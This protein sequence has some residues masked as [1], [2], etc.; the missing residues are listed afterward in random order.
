MSIDVGK[1]IRELLYEHP[2]VIVPGLGG[3][4]ST[5]APASVDYVQGVVSPPSK[6]IEFNP[7]FV[8]NDGILV[9]HIQKSNTVTFQEAKESVDR[10]VED[11]K[12][13][14]ERR[15]IVEVTE[16][17]RLYKDY[18][19]KIRFMPEGTNFN[20]EAYGLPAVQFSP[21]VRERPA[22]AGSAKSSYQPAT[23][24]AVVAP[25]LPTNAAASP[26][27]ATPPP[28]APKTG[29]Q[30][31]LPWIVLLTAIILALSIYLLFNGNK[32]QAAENLESI[33]KERL[34]VKPKPDETPVEEEAPTENANAGTIAPPANST[35]EPAA[36]A[37]EEKSVP[38]T[39]DTEED[40]F[41]PGKKKCFIVVHS[42]GQKENAG[43]FARQLSEAG[44]AYDT[45]KVGDLY[46]VG[47]V[48][49]YDSPAQID[50]TVEEL[51]SKFKSTPKV[52]DEN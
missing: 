6:N 48:L 22:S 40:T 19:H 34:N 1:S 29:L 5:P 17:G 30:A 13:A 41:E 27:A 36:K 2:A 44:Y 32:K 42:F 24:T 25:V 15:E 23:E 31:L 14:L 12:E 8:V 21:V 20:A 9:N 46:R 52:F 51:S 49:A 7:N 37:P 18:E 10:F 3:F 43:K 28:A 38:D 26:D 16:V 33:D 45:R 4:T 35:A 47:V 11:L 39:E 50:K